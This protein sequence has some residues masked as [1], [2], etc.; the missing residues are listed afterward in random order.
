MAEP[1]KSANRNVVLM[2]LLVLA[3]MGTLVSFSVPLYRAFCNATGYGGTTQQAAANATKGLQVI[4]RPITVRFNTDIDKALPWVFKPMIKSIKTEVGKPTLVNFYARNEAAREVTGHAV[5]N[6]TPQKAGLYFS[7]IQCFCFTEQTL[8]PG[9][10]VKM[11]VQF[12]VDPGIMKDRNLDDVNTITL[13][14]TF[15]LAEDQPA[16]V[17]TNLKATTPVRVAGVQTRK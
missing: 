17:S 3:G 14:Y 7:K 1:K 8:K 2:S 10:E 16:T 4:D 5:F 13:S 12:Y 11:P 9:E 6:V 15:Y